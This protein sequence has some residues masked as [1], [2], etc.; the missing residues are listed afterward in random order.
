MFK[1]IFCKHKN[2]IQTNEMWS[3]FGNEHITYVCIDCG[4]RFY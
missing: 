3:Y 2:K 4:K 1:K